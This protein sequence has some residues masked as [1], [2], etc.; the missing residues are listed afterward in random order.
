MSD[1]DVHSQQIAE[2]P[3]RN[4]YTIWFVVLSFTVPVIAAYV[5]FFF[6]E[7]K[8]FSNN[9]D[10]INPVK[11]FDD[12]QMQAS[13]D[14]AF[15]SEALDYKWHLIMFKGASC[16]EHCA[17][18]LTDMRQINRAVKRPHKIRY[19]IA[20]TE[21]AEAAFQ[22]LI[23]EEFVRAVR[24]YADSQRATQLLSDQDIARSHVI[25]LVDPQGYIVMKFDTGLDTALII[26]DLNRLF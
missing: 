21:R 12:L 26:K 6:G 10:F 1:T 15:T 2:P 18:R 22:Q 4:P 19:M 13:D 16:D 3:K 14:S 20:H 23:D 11:V 25:Y 8:S 5:I 24:V 7:V 9:G 17:R